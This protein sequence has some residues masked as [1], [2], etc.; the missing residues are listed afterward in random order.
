[1]NSKLK[2]PDEVASKQIMTSLFEQ[3]LYLLGDT[4]AWIIADTKG[5]DKEKLWMYHANLE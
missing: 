2:L 1:V 4:I 3:S 5:Y